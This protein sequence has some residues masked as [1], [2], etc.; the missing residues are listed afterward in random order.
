MSSSSGSPSPKDTTL[1]R[2]PDP[3]DKGGKI[4]QNVRIY[5]LDDTDRTRETSTTPLW[6]YQISDSD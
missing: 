6:P 2:P 4:L 5:L 3:E 1:L